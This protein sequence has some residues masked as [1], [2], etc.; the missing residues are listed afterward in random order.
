MNTHIQNSV[1]WYLSQ[2]PSGVGVT[3]LKRRLLISNP[4]HYGVT[5]PRK[6]DIQNCHLYLPRP[7]WFLIFL[8]LCSSSGPVLFQTP[9]VRREV[10]RTK[11]WII[12]L[13]Q[14]TC[15]KRIFSTIGTY[16]DVALKASFPMVLKIVPLTHWFF[17]IFISTTAWFLSS[18]SVPVPVSFCL[19]VCRIREIQGTLL[20][21]KSRLCAQ[22]DVWGQGVPP[23]CA[24]ECEYAIKKKIMTFMF[25]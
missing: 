6:T 12:I 13:C 24:P 25:T 19:K 7:Q 16:A 10:R 5:V 11:G 1:F 4:D 14:F 15:L 2:G 8:Q 23:R 17:L 21:N 18:L 3:E 22:S 9:H 20:W